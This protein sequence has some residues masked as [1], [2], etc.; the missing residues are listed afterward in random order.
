M[1][2]KLLIIILLIILSPIYTLA[3]SNNYQDKTALITNTQIED[4]KI[5]LYLGLKV[6]Q[7][8]GIKE[9]FLFNVTNISACLG[10]IS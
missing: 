10:K 6:C 1:K 7:N 9:A 8:Y 3:I 5:N 4:N 2:K